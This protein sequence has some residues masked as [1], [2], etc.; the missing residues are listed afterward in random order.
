MGPGLEDEDGSAEHQQE[1]E[2]RR[3]QEDMELLADAEAYERWL[4]Q[5]SKDFEERDNER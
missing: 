5:F 3:F 4:D 1:L 2:N